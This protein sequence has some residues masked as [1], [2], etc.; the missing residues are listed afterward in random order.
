MK[1]LIP[2]IKEL[3]FPKVDGKQYATLTQ[4]T[5]NIAD[6]GEKTIT[7]Q[8]KID[9]NIVPDFSHDWEIEFQ[10]EKY[11]MPLRKPQGSKENTSL[12][13]TIDLTFQHWAIYQLKRWP[14]V[15]I[16]QIAAGTYLPDEEVAT[17][18][19]NL[20]D[21]CIL[22]GQ[23]LEYYYGGAITIDF[24][25]DPVTGWQYKQEATIITISHTK[26]WNVLID[27]FHDKYGVRWEIK[28]AT[29]N[30]NTVKGG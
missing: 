21:F 2:D 11:I 1:R 17:V 30:S 20:K 9:G 13:S 14:F 23:V 29:D 24:N 15:T 3:N 25:D 16:Q 19:L 18:P 4:A 22:F 8:V 5:A 6:M 27:A 10:G 26:I 12:N 28:P 7:T